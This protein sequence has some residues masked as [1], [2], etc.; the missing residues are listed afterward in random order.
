M[1]FLLIIELKISNFVAEQNTCP[2]MP[3]QRFAL[4]V[5]NPKDAMACAPS[6]IRKAFENPPATNA[7]FWLLKTKEINN[8]NF[9]GSAPQKETNLLC[10]VRN[11][12]SQH[13]PNSFAALTTNECGEKLIK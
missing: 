5:E 11:A 12:E 2:Y 13:W 7:E 6:I 9:A 8:P 10:G 3:R 4:F 1:I